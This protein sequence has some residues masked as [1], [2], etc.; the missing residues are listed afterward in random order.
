M[1]LVT[2]TVRKPK[3][4]AFKSS[5]L[6]A[7]HAA[8]VAS[9]VPAT[10]RFQR[11]LELSDDDFRDNELYELL[12]EHGPAEKLGRQIFDEMMGTL[13]TSPAGGEPRTVLIFSPHPD[14]D[15]I[16]MGGTLIRLVEDL[17]RQAGGWKRQQEQHH[18]GQS[19]AHKA[20]P[21][22]AQTL[23]TCAASTGANA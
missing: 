17:G 4:A 16:S 15:V 6:D 1:P 12:R 5:V 22:R 10:D 20:A 23:S 3:D 14:D 19:P 2:V 18:K 13:Y 9:G 7:V 21:G 11:V 8:L